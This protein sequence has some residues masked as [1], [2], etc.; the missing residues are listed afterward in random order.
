M[1]TQGKARLG[2]EPAASRVM[3]Q[4]PWLGGQGD[5]QG[6]WT[7]D[8]VPKLRSQLWEVTANQLLAL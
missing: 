8:C 5:P 7:W 2:S 3:S 4:R 6:P 1:A